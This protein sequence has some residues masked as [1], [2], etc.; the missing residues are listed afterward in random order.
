[1]RDEVKGRRRRLLGLVLVALLPGCTVDPEHAALKEA[2]LPPLIQAH[3]FAYQ[4]NRSVGFQL[5]PDGGKL[6]WGGPSY[7]RSV[8]HVRNN[9]T[10][11]IRKYRI[12][13]G[14]FQ[15]S[16]DGRRLL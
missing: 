6:A 12:P 10:G 5:S 3:R 2:R 7:G 8:L 13:S 9:A 15:W 1:M 14:G 4:G 16:A 11:E